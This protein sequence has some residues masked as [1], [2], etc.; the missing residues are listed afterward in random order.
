LGWRRALRSLARSRLTRRHHRHHLSSALRVAVCPQQVVAA[1][2]EGH[3]RGRDGGR[4]A[5]RKLR[6]QQRA[7]G[8]AAVRGEQVVTQGGIECRQV[9]TG[10]LA[11]VVVAVTR[12]QALTAAT[13]TAGVVITGDRVTKSDLDHTSIGFVI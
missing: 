8:G 5:L 3:D 7:A 9:P 12:Q 4:L 13:L 1:D 11:E 2:G 6:I 10:P